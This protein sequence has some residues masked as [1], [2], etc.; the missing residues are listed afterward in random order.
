MP[1]SFSASVIGLGYVGLPMLHL[2][3]KRKIKCF[4]FD[5][6]NSK[7][8]LLKKGISYVSDIKSEQLNLIDKKNLFNMNDLNKIKNS[9]FLIFCL[10]TPFKNNKPDV[11]MIKS[12]FRKII[13]F[14]RKKQTIILESTV[15]PGATLK[16]FKPFLS[17]KFKIGQ[18][19][20][21]GY[22]PERLSPG[23]TDKKI[24]KYF[25]ENT[26]KVISG[27]NKKSL[28]KVN[29]LYKKVFKNIHKAESLEIAEMSKLVENSYRSVNIGLVNELKIICKNL[30]IDIS[31]VIETAG[32]KPFGFNVFLP[33]PGVGGHCIPVDPLFLKWIAQKNG[34]NSRFINLA[35]TTNLKITNWVLDQ[36][37]KNEPK[38]KSKF[39]KQKILVVGL[40]YKADTND[41]RE[42]PSLKII[43][44]L[45]NLNNLVD[46]NDSK[47]PRF[48]FGKGI[49]HSIPLSEANK[50]DCVIIITNHSNLN[51]G[52]ILKKAKKIFDTRGVYSKIS[53]KKIFK[54]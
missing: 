35:R 54:I 14:L 53:K 12:A 32:T 20:Y 18:N 21:L 34:V 36:I 40:A 44:K 24:Y 51:K 28:I 2:L 37:F 17:K 39:F 22:S 46:Y 45:K 4:G 11:S 48:K 43:K 3:S 19:F 13:P 8:E 6:D 9:D 10:P 31:K 33:G 23:Q 29:S 26:T 15:F 5:I 52:L 25:L 16:I 50:Y 38:I 30:N 1:S 7:V 42:S 27:F 49:N 47:I 41:T